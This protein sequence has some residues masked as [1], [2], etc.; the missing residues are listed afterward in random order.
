MELMKEI[1]SKLQSARGRTYVANF[2]QGEPFPTKK[3]KYWY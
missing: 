1:E 3:K 2:L